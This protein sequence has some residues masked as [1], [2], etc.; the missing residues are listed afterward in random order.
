MDDTTEANI[1]GDN[2][3]ARLAEYDDSAEQQVA[4]IFDAAHWD[5]GAAKAERLAFEQ[6]LYLRW[7][8]PLEMLEREYLYLME[9]GRWFESEDWPETASSTPA[10]LRAVSLLVRRANRATSEVLA[11]LRSGHAD[12]ALARCRTLW[13]LAVVA[14]VLQTHDD[15]VSEGYLNHS[16]IDA[17]AAAEDL[18][19]CAE[20]LAPNDVIDQADLA[21]LRLRKA[22]LIEL[23]DKEFAKPNGWMRPI[24]P[25][26]ERLG[27]AALE[28]L[29]EMDDQR[30]YYKLA[31][32]NVHADSRS[33]VDSIGLPHDVSGVN[34]GA[35]DAGLTFPGQR[36][37]LWAGMT[38]VALMFVGD[39]EEC[40][41][42]ARVVS[43]LAQAVFDC[44]QEGAELFLRGRE[45]MLESEGHL[46]DSSD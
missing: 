44:F 19:R 45:E 24:L 35:S 14:I 13:E 39:S 38:T 18:D 37:A 2:L 33:L 32:L 46:Q 11:L 7:E 28:R 10:K 31:C 12:G 43:K 20:T 40:L 21:E 3:I 6:R 16:A 27:F 8:L 30:P 23:Y 34:P 17:L 25:A 1:A 42:R 4:E 9:C 36:C 22:E 15:S 5:V 29:I 41:L 26:H